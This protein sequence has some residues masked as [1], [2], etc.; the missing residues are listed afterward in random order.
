MVDRSPSETCADDVMSLQTVK[1]LED[2]P[3]IEAS[4]LLEVIQVLLFKTSLPVKNSVGTRE[5]VIVLS[6]DRRWA[7]A[8][9][10]SPSPTPTPVALPRVVSAA[11]VPALPA[12]CLAIRAEPE[13]QPQR[14]TTGLAHGQGPCWGHSSGQEPSD[15]GS[16]MCPPW[17]L[18]AVH[19]ASAILHTAPR[20]RTDGLGPQGG[21]SGVGREAAWEGRA[22]KEPRWNRAH[23]A[24]QGLWPERSREPWEA[25]G[26]TG[27]G[28]SESL[29]LVPARSPLRPDDTPVDVSDSHPAHGC[30]RECT[31][32]ALAFPWADSIRARSHR[33][34]VKSVKPASD[35]CG[36]TGHES[37][38]KL[39]T[40]Y[41]TSDREIQERVS[42]D[43]RR[44]GG[45]RVTQLKTLSVH[46]KRGMRWPIGW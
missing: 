21:G 42:L 11:Q 40:M 6:S 26:A 35:L 5:L 13:Q 41:A 32:P 18:H 10:T 22:G 36:E 17:G 14:G 38:N 46:P 16:A 8:L 34:G 12:P 43:K 24:P 27:G 23:S 7:L 30:G 33:R 44:G 2:G 3:W 37:L 28:I 19:G 15:R 25:G 45:G 1:F 29:P 31:N 9:G 4:S 39:N 20:S